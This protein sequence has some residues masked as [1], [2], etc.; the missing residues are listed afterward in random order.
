MYRQ[1]RAAPATRE[2][3]DT[4]FAIIGIIVVLGGVIGGYLLEKGNLSVLWQPAELVII[5]GAA[6]GSFL[7]SCTPRMVGNAIK[8]ALRVFSPKQANKQ[9][10]LDI[11][12]VLSELLSVARR[13]GVIAIEGDVNNPTGS[14]LFSRYPSVLK[15]HH[16]RDFICD[17][18]KAFMAANMEA[19][20][21]ETLMDTDIETHHTEELIYPNIIA[22]TGDSLPGMGIV[23]AVLGVVITMGKISEPPEV[24]GHSIGAALVG[25]FLGILACYGFIGPTAANLENQAR[26]AQSQFLCVKAALLAF[27]MGW[28]PMMALE[29]ARRAIPGPERP[30]F[31]ELENLMR[32]AKK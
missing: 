20:E 3:T 25:T 6:V 7:I 1:G 16:V 30:S 18:M 15:N 23:A 27:A 29:S 21:F 31:E 13:E 2:K 8:A 22:K 9:V 12:S 32:G 24:L 26:E 4:M 14:A 28:P 19:H 10:F 17:N 5:G 11:L